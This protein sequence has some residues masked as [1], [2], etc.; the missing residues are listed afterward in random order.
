MPP[1][2]GPYGAGC[3]EE[4]GRVMEPRNETCSESWNPWISMPTESVRDCGR[5]DFRECFRLRPEAVL[6]CG[7]LTHV[8]NGGQPTHRKS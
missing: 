1:R 7:K 5:A 3:G 2:K 8:R 6:A 4:T